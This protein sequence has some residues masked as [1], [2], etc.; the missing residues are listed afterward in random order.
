MV[1]IYPFLDIINLRLHIIKRPLLWLL[2]LNH[3]SLDL[4]ELLET[5]SL[6]LFELLLLWYEQMKAH[7]RCRIIGRVYDLMFKECML[8][9]LAWW[10][11]W[12]T[13]TL[14]CSSDKLQALVSCFTPPFSELSWLLAF[15]TVSGLLL[16]L[17]SI[18][19]Q[20]L[21]LHDQLIL[22]AKTD[23][24][25]LR[26]LILVIIWLWL[27][28]IVK[29]WH[30]LIVLGSWRCL[31]IWIHHWRLHIL[32][33]IHGLLLVHPIISLNHLLLRNLLAIIH[34]RGCSLNIVNWKVRIVHHAFVILEA[35]EFGLL[36]LS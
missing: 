9:L 18:N 3:H 6:H 31:R 16:V 19:V 5:V 26:H 24:L 10:S 32:I 29:L 21:V 33:V 7:G 14:L 4:F 36:G 28:R 35:S 22:V 15:K 25:V 13:D 1:W 23:Q 8:N 30:L 34:H 17:N 11:C 12:I 2:H 20:G 27:V